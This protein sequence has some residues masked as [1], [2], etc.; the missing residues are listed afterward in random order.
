MAD[1]SINE[2][3]RYASPG[4]E[5]VG[6]HPVHLPT[7]G[8]DV[9]PAAQVMGDPLAL[10][11][12]SFGIAVGVV[13]VTNAGIIAPEE[14]PVAFAA[15][16]ASGFLT[17]LIAGLW[18][19]RRG[20][21]FVGVVFTSWSGFFLGIALLALIFAPRIADAGGS[22]GVAFGVY[23]IAWGI[24]STYHWIAAFATIKINIAIFGVG[25]AALYVLGV[26]AIVDNASLNKV[27]GW[28]Q[29][30]AGAGL[31]YLSAATLINEMHGRRV[32][33]VM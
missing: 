21:T 19:F 25:T 8:P 10:G 5:R 3:G 26:A 27:G 17:Q 20:E 18:A 28:L 11:L 31:L 7:A 33:P 4:D 1:L 16:L 2:T 12:A 29:I 14:A 9:G 15:V 32:L 13:G 24:I 6:H 23:L 30:L 22:V